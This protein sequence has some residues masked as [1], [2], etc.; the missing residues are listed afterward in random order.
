MSYDPKERGEKVTLIMSLDVPEL[1]ARSEVLKGDYRGYVTTL[2]AH[3][4]NT[5][6]V[7]I[8]TAIENIIYP[9]LADQTQDTTADLD[10]LYMYASAASQKLLVWADPRK[11][12]K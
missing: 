1:A 12:G 8:G 3:P 10:K 6:T 11:M 7:Y 4:D 9:L 5:G 2:R